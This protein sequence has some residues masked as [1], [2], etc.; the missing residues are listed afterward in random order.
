MSSII[1]GGGTVGGF[2][3]W[4]T[5]LPGAGKSTIASRLRDELA[6]KGRLVEILDGDVLRSSLSIGLGFSRADRDVQVRRLGLIARLLSRNG[7]VAI[8]A[9]VSP[10]RAAR[11]EVRAQQ[12]AP[13]IEV[14]VDCALD[15]VISRDPKGLYQ[16]ALRGEIANF[17]GVSDP[18]EAPEPPDVVVH[19]DAET[20]DAS[21]AIVLG[22]LERLRLVERERV[23]QVAR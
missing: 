18:Y 10:Y 20:A 15:V 12:D 19:T 8:V 6:R 4:L 14:F 22:A 7:V 11:A 17:T 1:R 13:F 23:G 16:R 3:V 21:T 2:T 9:A 5:G